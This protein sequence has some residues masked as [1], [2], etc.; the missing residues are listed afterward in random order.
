MRGTATQNVVVRDDQVENLRGAQQ[1][2]DTAPPSKD[3][4]L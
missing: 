1:S 2:Y 3:Y 4:G